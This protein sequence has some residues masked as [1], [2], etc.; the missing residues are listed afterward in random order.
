MIA[1]VPPKIIANSAAE[2]ATVP[3]TTPV[4]DSPRAVAPAATPALDAP[5]VNGI[6]AIPPIKS[7]APAIFVLLDLFLRF[8]SCFAI[9]PLQDIGNAFRSIAFLSSVFVVTMVMMSIRLMIN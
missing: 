4:A 7:A 2:M 6:A 5:P 1:T 8:L 9:S 3:A